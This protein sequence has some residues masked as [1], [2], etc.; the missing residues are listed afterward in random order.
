M[1]THMY[2]PLFVSARDKK[3]YIII[4]D[5]KRNTGKDG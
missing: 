5:I 3:T 2:A 4:K 1:R